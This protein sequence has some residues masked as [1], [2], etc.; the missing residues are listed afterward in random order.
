MDSIIK[1]VHE[2]LKKQAE[3]KLAAEIEKAAEE[4][5]PVPAAPKAMP[6]F[7]AGDAVIVNYKIIEGD[8]VRVQAYRGDV[9]QIKGHGATRTFTV[10]KI[11][12]SIGVERIFPLDSPSIDSVEVIKRGKVRRARLFYLRKYVGKRARIKEL[13]IFQ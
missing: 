7:R 3:A 10:R 1:L 5:K 2:E 4:G 6:K 13:R 9:I 8:K 11:S 12:N